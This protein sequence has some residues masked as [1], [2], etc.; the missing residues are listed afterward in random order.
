[1][2]GEEEFGFDFG[3]GVVELGGLLL[4]G[5]GDGGLLLEDLVDHFAGFGDVGVVALDFGCAVCHL[6]DWLVYYYLGVAL[7]HDLVDLMA[8]RSYQ[9]RNHA[10]GN[11]YYY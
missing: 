10:L 9:Q 3:F 6:V 7:A 11:E 5:V 2:I 4:D 1:M 8:F